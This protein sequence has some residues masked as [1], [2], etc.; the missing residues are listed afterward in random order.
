MSEQINLREAW[1]Q[2]SKH[3]QEGTRIPTDFAHYGPY[4]PN[5]DQLQLVG[6]VRGKRVLEIGCGGGQCAIAFAK[7]GAIA[8]G[9][10]LSDEQ[11]AFARRLAKAEGVQVAFLQRSMEDLSPVPSHSQEVVFSAYALPY[12]QTWD[13]CLAEVRRVLAPAGLFVFSLD[14]PFWACLAE[15]NLRI[16]HSYH[17]TSPQRWHW[18]Y[19]DAGVSARFEAWHHKVSTMLCSLGDAGFDVLD[20]L[21]PEP[22]ESGSGQDALGDYYSPARQRMVPATIIWRASPGRGRLC[23]PAVGSVAQAPSLRPTTSASLRRKW[24]RISSCYQAEHNIPTDLVHYGPH[25]PNEDQLQLIG[26]VRGRRVLEVGCGGGQCSIAFATRGAVVTGI[27]LSDRQVEF[28]RKLAA[29]NGVAA[30]FLQGDA[31]DLSA[32]PEASQDVVFSAYALQ[33][34]AHMDRCFSEVARVLRAG[35]SFVFSLDHPFWYCLAEQEMV[36]ESSYFDTT[37]WYE[38]EQAGLPAR[39]RMTEHHRTVGEWYRL[40]RAAGFEVVKM[41]E[42]EP[43]ESGSGQDWGGCYAPERQRMVPATIIWEA[44]KPSR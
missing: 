44:R 40:L 31:Q 19:P 33:F 36:V 5:E 18:D 2:I 15:A 27:D 12:L 37:Y 38:W 16:V 43:V 39:P 1:N 8:T 42:P 7:R 13:R 28:A 41:V 11:I 9:V 26:D 25:C 32:I 29:S 10:D 34:V 14:H 17:D 22:V 4:C 3:Y 35:G 20:I 24:N 23:T 21:E 30:T 6:D